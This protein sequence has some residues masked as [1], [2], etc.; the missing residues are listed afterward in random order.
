MSETPKIMS[1]VHRTPEL[2]VPA[3]C[4]FLRHTEKHRSEP[5]DPHH[6]RIAQNAAQF[7]AYCEEHASETPRITR[8]LKSSSAQW[9]RTA[10]HSR[11]T[12]ENEIQAR[13]K[14]G[15]RSQRPLS[16]ARMRSRCGQPFRGDESTACEHS[17]RASRHS[18]QALWQLKA[19]T[20][21]DPTP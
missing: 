1:S 7:R 10:P 19:L 13:P 20:T 5:R 15:P 18:A 21:P 9:H 8:R 6:D 14:N 3:S 17:A 2:R 11:A 4:T 12:S 16:P